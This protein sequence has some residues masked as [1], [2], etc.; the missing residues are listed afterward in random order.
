MLYT[1]WHVVPKQS[2]EIQEKLSQELGGVNNVV[3]G[4]LDVG[5]DAETVVV[6]MMGYQA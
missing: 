4:T 6:V 2:E 1:P 5:V 3:S